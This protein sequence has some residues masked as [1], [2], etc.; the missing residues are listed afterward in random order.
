M[1]IVCDTNVLVS[2]ILFPGG[3]PDKIVRGIFSGRFQHA[4]SPDILTELKRV[5]GSKLGMGEDITKP[6]RE[7]LVKNSRV[8][9]PTERLSV[10]KEDETDNRI[11]ECAATA[12]AQFLIT[13]D[14]KHLLPL[15]NFQ[16]IKIVSPREFVTMTEII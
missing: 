8:V 4:T 9:Y 1:I 14:Q 15:K 12:D 5:L 3:L 7:L 2:A 11:L 6:F 16:N 10:V 13:G